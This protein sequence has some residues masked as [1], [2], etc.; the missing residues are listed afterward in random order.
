MKKW[1]LRGGITAVLLL[2]VLL[3]VVFFALNPLARNIVESAG[4]K[5]TGVATTLQSV[6]LHP[7]RGAAT[8]NN[9]TLAN[10]DGF[11]GTLFELGQAHVK[12]NT[13]SAL[14][15]EVVV[16][17]VTLDGA[18][19]R[20]AFKDG[21]LN[22]MEL[23]K[24]LQGEGNK[25]TNPST[26]EPSD[27]NNDSAQGKG[28]VIHDLSVTNTRVLG[29]IALPGL[30]P[31]TL[32]FK[33]ADIHKT[34]LRGAEMKDVINLVLETILLNTAQGLSGMAPNLDALMG[35]LENAANA[36]LNKIETH[37]DHAVQDTA[38]QVGKTLD[39]VEK[40]LGGFLDGLGKETRDAE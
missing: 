22:I 36:Q 23:I 35:D 4:T 20:V 19:V 25:E 24:Q 21:K 26:P 2:V 1:L 33:I 39:D 6:A 8:L 3:A 17:N 13:L 5:G 27:G 29:D 12:I 9:L 11:S 32:D 28:F 30:S 34:N 37:L 14:G 18:T 10:P 16:P 31:Q 7:L 40:K 38:D 15:S